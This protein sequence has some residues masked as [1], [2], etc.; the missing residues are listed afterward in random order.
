MVCAPWHRSPCCGLCRAYDRPDFTRNALKEDLLSFSKETPVTWIVHYSMDFMEGERRIMKTSVMNRTITSALLMLSMA[1]PLAISTN[2]RSAALSVSS[3]I[4]ETIASPDFGCGSFV[5]GTITGTGISSLLGQV[6]I[7]AKD[8]I[9]PFP[10]GH[11]SFAG[12]MTFGTASGSIFADYEGLFTPTILPS[13]FLFADTSFTITGGT[14][15]FQN[16]KGS[17]TFIGGENIDSGN[18]L[19]LIAGN[20]SNYAK[21]KSSGLL[22]NSLTTASVGSFDVAAIAALDP[23]PLSPGTTLGQYLATDQNAEVL[24][25]TPVPEPMSLALLG[26][27][28]ASFAVARRRRPFIQPL[29]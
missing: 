4:H 28:L 15:S 7:S 9:T 10:D 11:F 13:I 26:I 27:G 16:A 24:A 23:T 3:V 1:A 18:G 2:A 6:S 14:G 19:L 17:G 29:I 25:D 5:G 21:L 20:I 22:L 8:C 12:K